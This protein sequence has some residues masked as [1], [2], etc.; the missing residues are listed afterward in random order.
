MMNEMEGTN[1]IVREVETVKAMSKRLQKAPDHVSERKEAKRKSLPVMC[2]HRR[3]NRI[4]GE[5]V[6][7]NQKD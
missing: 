1:G 3:T 4:I 7:G 6:P 2:C 5:R